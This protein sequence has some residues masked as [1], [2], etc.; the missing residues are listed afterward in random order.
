MINVPIIFA[1]A[2]LAA[3]S[4]CEKKFLGLNPWYHYLEVQGKKDCE[5]VGFNIL[6]PNSDVPLILLAVI[7]GLLKIAGMVAV[8]YVIIGAITLI[9]SDGNPDKVKGARDT[10]INALIGL[11][12]VLI[13]IAF[14][15]YLGSRLA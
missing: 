11:A 1:K 8:A 12:T 14:V 13:A 5:I 10:I 3:D 4:D 7:D 9:T 6:P 2:L 15:T